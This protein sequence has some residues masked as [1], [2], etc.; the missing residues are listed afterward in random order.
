MQSLPWWCCTVLQQK[1]CQARLFGSTTLHCFAGACHVVTS[2]ALTEW[3]HSNE[4]RGSALEATQHTLQLDSAEMKCSWTCWSKHFTQLHL[5]NNG[6]SASFS[7]KRGRGKK[8]LAF[9]KYE[10]MIWKRLSVDGKLRSHKLS[11]QQGFTTLGS[12]ECARTTATTVE[13]ERFPLT[14]G[15]AHLSVNSC[16]SAS[17][18][19]T[20]TGPAC[21]CVGVWWMLYYVNCLYVFNEIGFWKDQNLVMIWPWWLKRGQERRRRGIPHT[22][23]WKLPK[24]EWCH[25]LMPF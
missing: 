12:A 23:I 6:S 14:C 16:T 22:E 3:L 9:S 13:E 2:A 10:T 18:H 20:A 21:H 8:D 7:I 17:G 25:V 11:K 19:W 5:P 15:S 4:W 24:I 1:L